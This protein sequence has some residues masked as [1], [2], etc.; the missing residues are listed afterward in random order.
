MQQTEQSISPAHFITEESYSV[1]SLFSQF[2]RYG[3]QAL[4]ADG[5]C[6]AVMLQAF[7][8]IQNVMDRKLAPKDGK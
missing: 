1:V 4:Y 3:L 5:E 7:D 6:P 8:V 2:K